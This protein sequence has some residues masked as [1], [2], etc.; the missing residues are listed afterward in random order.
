MTMPHTLQDIQNCKD[1]DESVI[2]NDI[3]NLCD[4]DGL[5]NTKKNCGNRTV[6]KYQYRNIIKCKRETWYSL[7]YIMK[8][9]ELRNQLWSETI[10]RNRSKKG[11][12]ATTSDVF[13]CWRI[14]KGPIVCFRASTSKYIY[15]LFNATS[16]MDPTAGW[17][18]RMLGAMSLGIKY[19]GI[20]T[21][22]NL[23]E[24]Y[25]KMIK[26]IV[27]DEP[28][29]KMIWKSCLDID[30]SKLDYDLVLTSPPY[31]NM[32]LYENMDPFQNK[33]DFYQKFLIPMMEKC[34]KGLK[35]GGHM[36]I[37]ISVKMFKD[38]MKYK[39]SEPDSRIDLRQSMGKNYATKSQ[40]YIYVWDK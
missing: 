31:I 36:C 20:D 35:K 16:V 12:K 27:G 5:E 26:D 30:Y 15:K 25:D 21:N 6:Y 37:N 3:K 13:E 38:L 8:N 29:Y 33:I 28:D 19:T 14:N 7:E 9:E 4:F 22:I 32:E 11:D 24:G 40:D 2:Y 34:Y 23:K 10:K 1:F 39:V 18:G 17:G